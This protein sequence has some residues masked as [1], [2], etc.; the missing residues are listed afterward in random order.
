M[1]CFKLS[2]SLSNEDHFQYFTEQLLLEQVILGYI[3]YP[4]YSSFLPRTCTYTKSFFI[5]VMI[6]WCFYWYCWWWEFFSV[7]S[8]SWIYITL[9]CSHH[10]CNRQWSITTVL[11]TTDSVKKILK[12]LALKWLLN[13]LLFK[14]ELLGV[15]LIWW[16]ASIKF[17]NENDSPCNFNFTGKTIPFSSTDII[18]VA[19]HFFCL[20]KGITFI[21]YFFHFLIKL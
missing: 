3:L 9:T 16:F 1:W 5:I 6:E 21:F 17:L 8:W 4:I 12:L 10:P 2:K 13:K 20:Q 18:M 15:M 11:R 7:F 14:T 19:V